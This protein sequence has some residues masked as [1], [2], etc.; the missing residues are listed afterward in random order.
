M[1]PKKKIIINGPLIFWRF[2]RSKRLA[3]KIIKFGD[4]QRYPI[5]WRNDFVIK[6][7]K[8]FAKLLNVDLEVI[9]FEKLPKTPAVLAPNHAS[10]FD[11]ALIM[12]ALENPEKGPD[13][14][15]QK[16]VF[17][18]KDDVKENKR[19][20]GFADII[21]TFYIDRN[22]IKSALEVMDKMVEH[23][24]EN[25]KHLVIFPE[26]TRSENGEIQEFK[27]GAF[28]VAKQAYLPIVPVTI[29]NSFA[30]TD[31][32]RETRIKVQVI[33]HDPLKPMSFM[34]SD[35]KDIAARVQ[36]IVTSSWKKPEG[37]KGNFETK[38]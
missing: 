21:N 26:G 12:M 34:G 6:R 4:E 22:K 28:R 5:Q 9:G 1:N 15:N 19:F 17:L 7:S 16:A 3:K 24:K 33:F 35:T 29:N 11:P 13:F 36:K 30:I 10:S 32:E 8:Q 2:F 31:M 37:K 38:I 27:G 20:K 14:K 23:A 25:K 18:A